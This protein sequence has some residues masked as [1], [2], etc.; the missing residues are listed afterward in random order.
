MPAPAARTFAGG[1]ALTPPARTYGPI[2]KLLDLR[3]N[4]R[5]N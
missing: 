4:V 5:S 3:R 2:P 1:G